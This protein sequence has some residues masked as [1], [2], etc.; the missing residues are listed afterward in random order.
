MR[1][2]NRIDTTM[3]FWRENADRIIQSNDFALLQSKGS[4]SNQQMQKLAL[5]QYE[6]FDTRRKTHQAQLADRQDEEELRQLENDVK[7]RHGE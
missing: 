4:V 5:T 7:N 1:A 3:D 6:Q 2:K